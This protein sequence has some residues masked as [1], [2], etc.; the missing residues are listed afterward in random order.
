MKI[1]IESLCHNDFGWTAEGT[2][3]G[4]RWEAVESNSVTAGEWSFH[5]NRSD[6]DV[7]TGMKLKIRGLLIAQIHER[8]AAAGTRCCCSRC[9]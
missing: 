7:T 2:I 4:L 6:C 5:W 3:G 8:L 1:T 9:M